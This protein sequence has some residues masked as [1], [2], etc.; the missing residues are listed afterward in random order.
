[1]FEYMNEK[2]KK[3][4]D[5]NWDKCIREN[6][7]DNGTLIGLPYPYSV[8]NT[9]GFDEMYDRYGQSYSGKVQCR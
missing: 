7:A 2:L 1:M 8:P 6:R 4:I 5:T 9:G 3:F